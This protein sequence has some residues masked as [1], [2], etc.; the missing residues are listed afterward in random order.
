MSRIDGH[1][2]NITR[3]VKATIRRAH[4][5]G[6]VVAATTD[7]QHSPDS[8]HYPKKGRNANGCAVDL[9]VPGAM[10]AGERRLRLVA[11]QITEYR[12]AKRFGFRSWAE[13]LGPDND[14]VILGGA[15]ADLTE[16][17]PLEQAHDDHVHVARKPMPRRPRRPR[18]ARRVSAR[19]VDMV[20]TFEGF[21]SYVYRDAVG[22]ETIGFGE[23]DRA[24]IAR[25]RATGIGRT[26]ALRLLRTRL[27][28]DY[29]PAVR[30][31]GLP[32]T[33]NQ[34]DA[35][36]SFVYNVGP[37]ALAPTTG[38]GL[39]LRRRDWQGA[40]D[41]L[42]RWDKAGGHALP[43]LTRRRRAERALFLAK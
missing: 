15:R 11:F 5:A 29:A 25:Y 24:I 38:I 33:Q 32:L 23:T 8:W 14:Y 34:Y 6:L 12:Y 36:C 40:A 35:L 2:S 1:P 18:A 31:L 41:Q 3:R 20:A 19:G 26:A 16:G 10:T 37:G 9:T 21:R 4:K 43:G 22:V 28:R 17:S 30:A 7:G 27:N 13:I 42:L 39:A